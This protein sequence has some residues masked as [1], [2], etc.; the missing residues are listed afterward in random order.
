MSDFTVALLQAIVT[1]ANQLM[2]FSSIQGLEPFPVAVRVF[3]G[4]DQFA[5]LRVPGQTP[6]VPEA[7]GP[8]G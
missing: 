2:I 5:F 7:A 4:Y 8:D 1:P 3:V 6:F